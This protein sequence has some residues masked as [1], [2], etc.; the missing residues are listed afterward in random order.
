[1]GPLVRMR[2]N[3]GED[4]AEPHLRVHLVPLAGRQERV[5][6]GRTLGGIM[7]AGEEIVL[8]SQ[9]NRPDRVLHEVVVY[10]STSC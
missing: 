9:R 4:I 1:M 10:A 2:R 3:A 5:D 8:A 6:D 7:R